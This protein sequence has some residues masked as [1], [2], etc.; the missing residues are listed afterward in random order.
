[1]LRNAI[2][3]ATVWCL[4]TAGLAVVA[5][6]PDWGSIPYTP[7]AE[8]QAVDADGFGT[9][10]LTGP[11]KM[12]GVI[13]N[14][15][16][17]MLDSTP[18]AS[19]WLGGLWQ[20]YVQTVDTGDFGGTACWMG[21]YIGRIMGTHPEGSY[22]DVEWQA[23]LDRLT[24]DPV[25][26]HEFQ[27]GDLVEIRARAPG[28]H[29]NGKSNVNEQ[30]SNDPA[31]DFDVYL[32]EA[33]YGLP[34]PTVL[35]LADLKDGNDDFIFDPD[36]LVGPEHYQGSLVRINDVDWVSTGGWQPDGELEIQDGTGRTFPVKLG[37]G[38]GY[39]TYDPPA[40]P[41]DVIGILDQEDTNNGD[42]YLDGYRLWLVE[43]YDGNG[44]VLPAPFPLLGDFDGDG[45]V[46]LDDHDDLC[47]CLA[48][49]GTAPSPPPPTTIEECLEAFDFDE[50]DDVDLSDFGMFGQ[51]FTGSW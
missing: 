19:G 14:R 12:R 31:A 5:D 40:G 17:T 42:G 38:D 1:M 36:R 26:G 11:I 50:D 15:S 27:P 24:H 48:G 23:E 4:F 18:G 33:D 41:F 3:L 16:E 22:S 46:D 32:I 7:H 35:S 9:F 21:Q 43:D 8:Y 47:A 30:H 13:L 20:V 44:V 49:A 29:Y 10:P 2:V 34:M 6:E 28:L 25:S 37:L 39:S 45:D 51:S